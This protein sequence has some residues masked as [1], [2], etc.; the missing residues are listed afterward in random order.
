MT[1]ALHWPALRVNERRLKQLCDR[2]LLK[3]RMAQSDGKIFRIKMSSPG[4]LGVTGL[5][6]L[7]QPVKHVDSS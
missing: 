6:L 3:G 1:E 4:G 5:W 7:V 2:C